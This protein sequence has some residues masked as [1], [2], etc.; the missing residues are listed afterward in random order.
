MQIY[1]TKGKINEQNARDE[2]P[3]LTDS[4]IGL[5]DKGT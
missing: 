5:R 3:F 4:P 2:A 1:I